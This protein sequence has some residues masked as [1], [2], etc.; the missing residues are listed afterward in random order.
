MLQIVR[1]EQ[2]YVKLSKYSFG[3][4]K[5]EYLRHIITR[6]GVSTYP[7]KIEAMVNWPVPK[8]MKALTGF[9]GL[10]SYYIR[11]IKSFGIISRPLTN[12]LKKNSFKWNAETEVA[13]Q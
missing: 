2:L 7:T 11:F 1:K 3:Q 4:A 13:F 10:T 9:L 6:K 8:T 12:L 5:V